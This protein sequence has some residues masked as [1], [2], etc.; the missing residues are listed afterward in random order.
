MYIHTYHFSLRIG[1]FV[2]IRALVSVGMHFVSHVDINASMYVSI[3]LHR[4]THI[5]IRIY[6]SGYEMDSFFIDELGTFSS[7]KERLC[8]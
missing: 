8:M 7:L 1:N 5:S 2:W 3:Y 4:V 6:V